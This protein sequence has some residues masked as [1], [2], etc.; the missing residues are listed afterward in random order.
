MTETIDEEKIKEMFDLFDADGGGSIDV[1][2]LTHAL[3]NLGIS[4]TQA[5]IDAL[6]AQIDADGSGEIEFDEFVEVMQQLMAARDSATEMYKAF[7]YFSDG[8][9][10]ITLGDLRKTCIDIDDEQTEVAL[11]EMMVV[12]DGDKDGVVTFADFQHM[13]NECLANERAGILDG[14]KITMAANERDGVKL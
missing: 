11:A 14:R 6:V 3:V 9:E 4:D 7:K 10:R 5:E 12:A 2:E 1:A 13:M 8:K